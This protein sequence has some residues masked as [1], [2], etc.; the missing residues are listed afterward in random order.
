M[1]TLTSFT[2]RSFF[3]MPFA[4][5]A[6]FTRRQ[7]IEFVGL[8]MGTTYK[9]AAVDHE[10]KLDE[11]QVKSVVSAALADVNRAMSNWDASSEVSR[12]NA[13]P[14]GVESPMSSEL[15]EVMAAAAEVNA[16][17][18]GRFDTTL[19]P[20]IELWGF[21]APGAQKMPSNAAIATAK[22]QSGH[23]NVLRLGDA[24]VEKLQPDAQVYLAGIGKGYG[25]DHVGR[26]L[27]TLGI[28]DYLIE[29]GGD[30][31]ASGRNPD[32][33]PWQIGIESPNASDQGVHGVIGVSGMGLASSGDYRNFFEDSGQRYSHLID[34]V[35][36]RPVEHNTASA[37]VH[38]QERDAGRCLVHCH[39]HSG[40]R[41]RVGSGGAP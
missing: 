15:A 22:A 4:L 39:A 1:S 30:L 24:S 41:T 17:S 8:S 10:G 21:G 18:L 7:V 11:R 34:P 9:V 31:Y 38:R 36:G 5:A 16:A 27:E 20:L 40:P 19:G 3:V 23:A 33:L 2:R 37:T 25:A 35:T 26:A 13:A 14:A 12:L 29:I 32:G 6:C 28:R